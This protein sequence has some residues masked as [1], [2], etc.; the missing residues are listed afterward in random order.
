MAAHC[1]IHF[2]VTA[3]AFDAAGVENNY[4]T[5]ASAELS[6]NAGRHYTQRLKLPALEYRSERNRAIVVHRH[7]VH[8]VLGVVLRAARVQY[9]VRFDKPARHGR[10][11]IDG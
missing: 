2:R 8:N 9:A 6:R 10:D 7:A 11:H 4:T 3:A 5:Q 1:E